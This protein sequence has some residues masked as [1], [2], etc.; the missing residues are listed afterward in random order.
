MNNQLDSFNEVDEMYQA[1]GNLFNESL[2]LSK[3]NRK[4]KRGLKM[5]N[6]KNKEQSSI[7]KK[8]MNKLVLL[9]KEKCL[10]LKELEGLGRESPMMNEETKVKEKNFCKMMGEFQKIID[11]LITQRE[12]SNWVGFGGQ[13]TF[14]K[15]FKPSLLAR[16][17]EVL[18]L[19][20][21]S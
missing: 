12:P 5:T 11:L 16:P 1:Y 2:H 21:L 3:K 10:L 18:Y 13:F 4:L 15:Y 19:I 6:Q 14:S 9:K 17:I 8:V 7:V 20:F